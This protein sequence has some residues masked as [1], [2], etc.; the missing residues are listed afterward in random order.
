MST[1]DDLSKRRICLKTK[2]KFSEKI[3]MSFVRGK[4]LNTRDTVE[5]VIFL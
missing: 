5:K 1:F 4:N 3:T 2:N